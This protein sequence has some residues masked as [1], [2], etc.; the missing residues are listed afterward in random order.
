MAHDGARPTLLLDAGTGLRRVTELLRGRP[1]EGSILLGHLHW[2]HTQGLPFFRAGDRPDARVDLHLPAQGDDPAGVL[3]RGMSPPHFPIGPDQLR[4]TWRFHALDE[5]RRSIEGFEVLAREIP[6]KGG[7]TFGYRISDATAT[8]AYLSDHHPVGLGPGP[9]GFGPYHP[10]ARELVSGVDLLIHD[11][12]YTADEFPSRADFGHSSIDY[13]V[14]LAGACDVRSLL[15]FHHDPAR[16]D[17]ELD[18]IEAGLRN[19]PVAVSLA[20]EG[21]VIAL[22]P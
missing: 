6:H 21:D 15:L 13:A 17:E 1:F 22:A 8:F 9:D 11:A 4:G 20:I 16:T 14:G 2:D 10:A 7:R 5:G 3:A 12:Q 18:T 19:A